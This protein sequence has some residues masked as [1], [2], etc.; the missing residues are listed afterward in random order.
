MQI[1]LSDI[2]GNDL[3]KQRL[4]RMLEKGR[5]GN[6]LLFAGP[7]G[8]GKGLFAQALA[9]SILSAD[10]PT[11]AHRIKLAAGS[12]PDLKIYRPEKK[13]G[14]HSIDTMRQ[15]SADV[16]LAP[17]EA[18]HKVFIIYD[19][20]RMLPTSANA[21][22]K[23]FEEPSWDSVIIL[24][25]SKPETLLDT[26]QS[27]CRTIHFEPIETP[28]IAEFLQSKNKTKEEA[29]QLAIRANGS[30]A[31]ALRLAEHGENQNRSRLL[32]ILAAGGFSTYNSLIDCVKEISSDLDQIKAQI[33]ADAREELTPS[34]DI[35]LSAVQIGQ[36]EQEVEGIVAMKTLDE[37]TEL[38]NIILGWFRDLHLLH[39]NGN[40]ELLIHPDYHEALI[41]R[42]QQG[43][44]PALESIES[45]ISD[46]KLS[47]ERST[48]FNI[49]LENLFL[50]LRLV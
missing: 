29:E 7:D 16:Y 2:I 4:T 6:S 35:E 38:F 23:T 48:T 45:A 18:K 12:H 1:K 40:P 47:L 33:E 25:S 19:A 5:V 30:I 22:L 42:L 27:R 36:I 32:K 34:S 37:A 24:I 43:N 50:Q 8:V 15:F 49:C 39:V 3:A 41:Q 9:S 26:V 20:D 14:V 13:I 10:D 28:L 11:G 46:T 21:L 17:Y 31:Q 44:L